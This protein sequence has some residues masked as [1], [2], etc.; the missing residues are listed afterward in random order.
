MAGLSARI[1]PPL[2]HMD[3]E[4]VCMMASPSSRVS[5]RS[6][7]AGAS[8]SSQLY[9]IAPGAP[10]YTARSPMHRLYSNGTNLSMS[11][12]KGCPETN[13][14]RIECPHC[15]TTFPPSELKAHMLDCASLFEEVPDGGARCD[16]C[17]E[18]L[19]MQV[20][21]HAAP[22]PSYIGSAAGGDSVHL[23]TSP[24]LQPAPQHRLSCP[25]IFGPPPRPQLAYYMHS[26]DH[27][28]SRACLGQHIRSTVRRYKMTPEKVKCPVTECGT[29]IA[30]VD[31]LNFLSTEEHDQLQANEIELFVEK[32]EGVYSFCPNCTML[33]ERVP[34]EAPPQAA[35]GGGEVNG[36]TLS[37]EHL[38]HYL[39]Y[40]LRCPLC[41]HEFC[42]GCKEAPY[43]LGTT[44]AQ[45]AELSKAKL[46]RFCDAPVEN[47]VSS[48][49]RLKIMT[50]GAAECHEKSEQACPKVLECGHPCPGIKDEAACPPC[51]VAGCPSNTTTAVGSDWCSICY[52]EDL[53]SAPCVVLGCGHTFHYSC[54]LKQLLQKWPGPRISFG[55][56]NCPE[57]NQPIDHPA[58][59]DALD[60][61][62]KFREDVQKLALLRLKHEG[63]DSDAAVTA[64]EGAYYNNPLGYAEA[65]LSYYQCYVCE[66]PYFGGVRQCDAIA[67]E[68]RY[69]PTELVCAACVP[70]RDLKFC[71]LH[72]AD[73][74]EY[75]CKFCCSV[76]QWFCWG[77]THFCI[78]CHRLQERGDFVTKKKPSELPQCGGRKDCP[79]KVDHPQNGTEEFALG[80][81]IC[82]FS[83]ITNTPSY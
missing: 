27:V 32:S 1:P 7:D 63:M 83:A 37:A 30:A 81:A 17:G 74:I 65:V 57:C 51:L 24:L 44:C 55:F 48:P 23:L 72:G 39:G 29:V 12:T 18:H 28:F 78:A 50:C 36:H 9:Q 49:R 8:S 77:T 41:T 68:G 60:D 59:K 15:S 16:M 47:T 10:L 4:Q 62:H 2:Q 21:D 52:S 31:L 80:C 5:Q 25:E 67:E 14:K 56:M 35:G 61:L 34:T 6:H 82:R 58:L 3:D 22:V 46:C 70:S 66:R 42:A 33:F 26:C 43:H 45:F 11:P 38:E 71:E 64:P 40:R 69:N 54:I 79:L 75:K 13:P 76:A 53:R 20:D 19:T 73:F